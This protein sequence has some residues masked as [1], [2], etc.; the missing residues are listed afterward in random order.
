MPT[1]PLRGVRLSGSPPQ[2][3]AAP[4][5]AMKRLR[6][7]LWSFYYAPE[8][9][10]IAPISAEWARAMR[11]RGH[12]VEV[13]T[14]HPSYPRPVWGRA[15]RPY[16]EVRNGIR[17]LRLP[18]RLGRNTTRQRLLGEATY[19]AGLGLASPTLSTPDVIVATSPSFPALLPT[20]VNARLRGVPW[21]L[22]LQDILP[23]AAS[24]TGLIEEG[25]LIQAAKRFEKAAYASA[26][27]IA[28]LSASFTENLRSKGVPEG[29]L[30]RIYNPATRP[31]LTQPRATSLVEGHRVLTMGNVGLSQGLGPL[32]RAF[33]DSE[34][35]S[36]LG[37]HLLIA[38]DGVA[39][40]EVRK[41]IRSD[42]VT[43]TGVVSSDRLEYE[44]RRAAVAVVS[45]RYEG[46]EF[47]VPSKL[48]NF[49]GYGLPVLASVREDS[50]VARILRECEGGWVTDSRD[51][52][53]FATRLADVLLRPDELSRRGEAGR[54]FALE[55]FRIE[56]TADVFEDLMLRVCSPTV[57][58]PAKSG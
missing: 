32:V 51:P 1:P 31:V 56:R 46:A 34:S 13:I 44:L 58:E 50:E 53:A 28:V 12:H 6:I 25:R 40:P 42:R 41:E 17:V 14:A 15:V 38:G 19:A 20:M 33:E 4:D 52:E 8:P 48:M 7:Q 47:N 24:I 11:D 29:K 35:V 43:L 21:I 3:S 5:Y 18:V 57:S 16:R 37:A 27:R 36:R 23:E 26:A 54:R 9:M 45:Q 49:M 39:A 10:G 22:W 55:N 30:E 2:S